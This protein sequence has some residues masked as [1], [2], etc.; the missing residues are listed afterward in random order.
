MID[1]AE[2]RLGP[3]IAPLTNTQSIEAFKRSNEVAVLA[4]WKPDDQKFKEMFARVAKENIDYYSFG[5][6]DEV[7]AATAENISQPTIVLYKHYD[8]KKVVYEGI[9]DAD[10]ITA[11]V[12]TVSIPLVGEFNRKWAG[13][14]IH[15]V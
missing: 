10:A 14:Y 1:F 6:T 4:Y 5:A 15:K 2:R 11:F 9:F 12:D 8:D 3:L 13:R 7:E